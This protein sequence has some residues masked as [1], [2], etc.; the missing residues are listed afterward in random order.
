[1]TTSSISFGSLSALDRQNCAGY[2]ILTLPIHLTDEIQMLRDAAIAVHNSIGVNEEVQEIILPGPSGNEV[3][4]LLDNLVMNEILDDFDLP[5]QL[6]K[7]IGGWRVV[8]KLNLLPPG[9]VIP[10]YCIESTGFFLSLNDGVALPDS[11]RIFQ[12]FNHITGE[13]ARIYCYVFPTKDVLEAQKQKDGGYNSFFPTTL[14]HATCGELVG[15]D[16]VIEICRWSQRSSTNISSFP[17]GKHGFPPP[18]ER[19]ILREPKDFIPEEL[20]QAPRWYHLRELTW[21]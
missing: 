15:E 16:A 10:D 9:V 8:P 19:T 17:A 13:V 5:D 21:G 12:Y 4:F 14:I 20:R 6:T 7:Y 2:P 1:M 18:P 3:G 11:L